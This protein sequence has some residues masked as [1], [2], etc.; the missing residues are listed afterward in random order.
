[1]IHCQSIFV[2]SNILYSSVNDRAV[3][4][5]ESF[6]SSLI[7]EVFFNLNDSVIL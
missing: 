5:K 2:I 4:A 1:M 3:D 7:V 6:V